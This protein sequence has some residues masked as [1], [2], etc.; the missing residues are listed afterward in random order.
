MKLGVVVLLGLL[1]VAS[2]YCQDMD[3]EMDEEAIMESIMDDD[4]PIED[5]EDLVDEEVV[6]EE[7]EPRERR[8]YQP[9]PLQA[10]AHFTSTF[11]SEDEFLTKWIQSSAHKDGVDE[12]LAKYDG[13]WNLEEAVD[14]GLEGDLGL[15]L[16][17]KAKHSAIAARLNRPYVFEGKPF[18]VQYEVKFQAGQECG[19]AYIKLLSQNGKLNLSTFKDNTGYTIM[20]GPDRCGNDNKLH[21]I[22]RHKHPKTGQFEEKHAKKPTS[23][24]DKLFTDKKTHLYTL[25]VNPDQ[26]YEVLVDESIVSSGSL[27][28]DVEPAVNPPKEIIDEDDVKPADWDEREKVADAE[29]IKPEDW[30]ES[31]PEMIDDESA[32]KPDGWLEDETELIPDPDA[33]KPDDWDEDMDG[34][35]EAPMINNPECESAPGCGEWKQPQI[36]NLDHKGKWRAPM[37][38]NPNYKGKWKPRTIPNPDFFEDLN[39]YKMTTIDAVGL[40]LWSM[41]DQILFDNFIVTDSR[42]VLDAWTA[43]TWT[44]KHME[45]KRGASGKS[46]VDAVMDATAER[47]W[48][49][50][51]F[52]IVGVLPVILLIAYCCMSGSSSKDESAAQRK[53]TDEPTP[54]DEAEDEEEVEG[55]EEGTEEIEVEEEDSA[56]AGESVDAAGD[57]E[58]VPNG[59]KKGKS[60]LEAEDDEVDGDDDEETER[61]TSP[62]N[63]KMKVPKE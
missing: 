37:I 51:V 44:I 15:V 30:D 57:A 48:L 6:E 58:A 23:G 21:F 50:A 54:D 40:E 25:V 11:D 45:E 38:D 59:K 61:R 62:R 27:L 14:P 43:D 24:V 28:E 7:E 2:V 39:P 49:W 56:E 3:D 13:K 33:E 63:R 42:E 17:S 10:S 22:F 1:T 47:P 34:E 35:W 20:F 8:V 41:S 31:Q 55:D 32:E 29:A 12:G 36:K 19:G 53:K 4:G 18:I 9:P 52:I 60:Q 46:V 26:S 16:K 5:D